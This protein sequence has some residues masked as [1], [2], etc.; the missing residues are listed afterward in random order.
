VYVTV[1]YEDFEKCLRNEKGCVIASR[2]PFTDLLL[3][4]KGREMGL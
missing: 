3:R 1:K 2:N 4:D